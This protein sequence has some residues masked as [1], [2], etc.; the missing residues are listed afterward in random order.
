VL[1][2]ERAYY[3]NADSKKVITLAVLSRSGLEKPMKIPSFSGI[4]VPVEFGA[5]FCD[6][7]PVQ[8]RTFRI[9]M[10]PRCLEAA[11]SGNCPAQ[12]KARTD[13]T[14]SL[15]WGMR[16]TK[17]NKKCRRLQLHPGSCKKHGLLAVPL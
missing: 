6:S 16:V 10:S 2:G 3:R 11:I 14:D 17:R 4:A 7:R 12:Q 15:A 9:D 5:D 13:S 1:F 8:D